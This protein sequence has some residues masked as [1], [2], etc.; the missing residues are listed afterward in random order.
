[1]NSRFKQI[2]VPVDLTPKNTVALNIAFETAQEN[3]ATVTLLHVTEA[4]ESHEGEQDE[5]LREFTEKLSLQ[6]RAKL[7]FMSR[8]FSEGGVSV[9]TDVKIGRPLEEIIRYCAD[10]KIDLIVMSSH[11]ATVGEMV[12]DL[13]TLSYKVSV[14]CSCPILL[15]K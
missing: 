14:A 4:I 6:A 10:E 9:K 2:L 5:E 13:G 15:V 1:M 12:R 11:P 3:R 7:E 8:R